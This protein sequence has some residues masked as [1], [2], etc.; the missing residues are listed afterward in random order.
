MH[1]P[2]GFDKVDVIEERRRCRRAWWDDWF[3]RAAAHVVL[4]RRKPWL[5]GEALGVR[6]REVIRVGASDAAVV[7]VVGGVDV[8]A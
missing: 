3:A 5:L 1:V 4:M 2:A 6:A 7:F 8:P